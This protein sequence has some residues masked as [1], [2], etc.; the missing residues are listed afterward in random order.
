MTLRMARLR[1]LIADHRPIALLLLAAVLAL[2]IAVPA[3]WMPQ[4]VGQHGLVLSICDGSGSRTEVIAV[5][6]GVVD[7]ERRNDSVPRHATA[8]AACPYAVLGLAIAS[9]IAPALADGVPPQAVAAPAW[10]VAPA[11]S[12]LAHRPRPPGRAPPFAG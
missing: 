1:A 4:S 6:S 2:R 10:A 12:D 11:T 7:H 9:P 3:G 8:A 5:A